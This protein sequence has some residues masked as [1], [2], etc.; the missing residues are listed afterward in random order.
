MSKV[1]SI[2]NKTGDT[3]NINDHKIHS[4][5]RRKY[6][7][8]EQKHYDREETEKSKTE[9]TKT[10][11]RYRRNQQ[12]RAYTVELEVRLAKVSDKKPGTYFYGPLSR[13]AE[14]FENIKDITRHMTLGQNSKYQE[15]DG[16][17]WNIK[18]GKMAYDSKTNKVY[19]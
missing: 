2:L 7:E 10:H 5:V 11:E 3:T 14:D 12:R 1:T 4:E 15:K 6:N 16:Q 18:T 17:L 9:A 13:L 8:K 19:E